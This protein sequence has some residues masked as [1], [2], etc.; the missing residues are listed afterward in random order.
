MTQA[1]RAILMSRGLT[2]HEMELMDQ[3]LR[4][5]GSWKLEDHLTTNLNG[6][7]SSDVTGGPP[8]ARLMGKLGCRLPGEL[9]TVLQELADV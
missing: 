2:V 8:L 9:E 5:Y 1:V 4:C 7:G 6:D 3:L